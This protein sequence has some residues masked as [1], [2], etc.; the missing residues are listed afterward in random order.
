ME[1]TAGFDDWSDAE[2][3]RS[4]VTSFTL[5]TTMDVDE[6][7]LHVFFGAKAADVAREKG[8]TALGLCFVD[9][10]LLAV[11]VEDNSDTTEMK[12]QFW[13]LEDLPANQNTDGSQRSVGD[14]I[15][16]ELKMCRARLLLCS[17]L[18]FCGQRTLLGVTH[19]HTS[20]KS[21]LWIWDTR[22]MAVLLVVDLE[23]GDFAF[24]RVCKA[25]CWSDPSDQVLRV[26]LATQFGEVLGV[27]LRPREYNRREHWEIRT[28]IDPA[29][30]SDFDSEESLSCS[31]Y[32][33][34]M[35]QFSDNEIC[36]QE[37][38]QLEIN[39]A[40]HIY[41]WNLESV[42]LMKCHPIDPTSWKAKQIMKEEGIER[43][44]DVDEELKEEFD[45][46]ARRIVGMYID[47]KKM[48]TAMNEKR[49]HAEFMQG[50]AGGSLYSNKGE[51]VCWLLHYNLAEDSAVSTCVY[52]KAWGLQPFTG[53]LTSM[54]MSTCF[55][56]A[57]GT[58]ADPL[59]FDSEHTRVLVWTVLPDPLGFLG[60]GE[61]GSKLGHDRSDA[62]GLAQQRLL[63]RDPQEADALDED[64]DEETEDVDELEEAEDV[65]GGGEDDGDRAR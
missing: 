42:Y 11:M 22:L 9:E 34:Y 23:L 30:F 16:A 43:W 29:S 24:C 44:E 58:N 14:K 5:D 52:T 36:A 18:M 15:L 48:I 41:L 35:A 40:R 50:P 45:S 60:F 2:D 7:R 61:K 28:E 12:M 27:E 6:N 54:S 32:S 3:G 57:M 33:E 20:Y 21:K 37:L 51:I 49:S 46:P 38:D 25:D 64:E 65:E 47:D 19:P 55:L 17:D 31:D 59:S 8:V 63:Y 26:A 56:V 4:R 1:G 62:V 53:H 39:E 10:D 13:Q